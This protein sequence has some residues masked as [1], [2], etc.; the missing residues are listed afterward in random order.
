[1]AFFTK[2]GRKED[3]ND[4]INNKRTR[5]TTPSVHIDR[6]EVNLGHVG[7]HSNWRRECELTGNL[8]VTAALLEHCASVELSSV[9]GT[10]TELV[11]ASTQ[12]FQELGILAQTAVMA[13]ASTSTYIPAHPP[14]KPELAGGYDS[15]PVR[16]V[17]TSTEREDV[18][19]FH[20]RSQRDLNTTLPP[21]IPSIPE[22]YVYTVQSA[23]LYSPSDIWKLR[24]LKP[25]QRQHEYTRLR[26]I[27]ESI[28]LFS[29]DEQMSREIIASIKSK[30]TQ[31]HLAECN[32]Y[33]IHMRHMFMDGEYDKTK[34][35]IPWSVITKHQSF[36]TRITEDGQIQRVRDTSDYPPNV[37]NRASTC[38]HNLVETDD[39][40]N[41]NNS[42]RSSHSSHSKVSS[43]TSLS[44]TPSSQAGESARKRDA[45]ILLQQPTPTKKRRIN[46]V[47][48]Q[49]K[50]QILA[51]I[52][53]EEHVEAN[54]SRGDPL[55]IVSDDVIYEQNRAAIEEG[56]AKNPLTRKKAPE[57]EKL[58]YWKS[59]HSLIK[60]A[61]EKTQPSERDA[62]R[63]QGKA[64]FKAV[65]KD[66]A[67][68]KKAEAKKYA[69][70]TM[71]VAVAQ[72]RTGTAE[73][74][75]PFSMPRSHSAGTT[76]APHHYQSP[77]P[78]R[79]TIRP[80]S[81]GCKVTG[82]NH[83]EQAIDSKEL[84]EANKE[85][86]EQWY[87]ENFSRKQGIPIGG[88]LLKSNHTWYQKV[89]AWMKMRGLVQSPKTKRKLN[90]GTPVSPEPQEEKQEDCAPRPHQIR[91]SGDL[92]I[93]PE[94]PYDK[95]E[96]YTRAPDGRYA[97]SHVHLNPPKDCCKSGLTRAGK[98]SA[99]KKDI[100][101]WN[102]RIEKLIDNKE[103]DKRH[104]TWP[105]WTVPALRKKHQ[106][107]LWARQEAKTKADQEN[108]K[109]ADERQKKRL[110][111][112]SREDGQRT[113]VPQAVN[114]Q[115]AAARPTPM[116]GFPQRYVPQMIPTRAS[117][118]LLPVLQPPPAQP[119]AQ[120]PTAPMRRRSDPD[121]ITNTQTAL[122][123]NLARTNP[124]LLRSHDALYHDAQFRESLKRHPD[125]EMLRKWYL[126]YFLEQ[127][128]QPL[129]AEQSKLLESGDPS[130]DGKKCVTAVP[131]LGRVDELFGEYL[132]AAKAER[133][134]QR[135][136]EQSVQLVV[137]MG[138]MGEQSQHV[139]VQAPS[140]V[141]ETMA[142]TFDPSART[143]PYDFDELF[144]DTE[145]APL[146]APVEQP[147]S[148]KPFRI[149]NP[150][151]L[152]S[153]LKQILG[154]DPSHLAEPAFSVEPTAYDT[155]VLR[156]ETLYLT[157]LP[158]AFATGNHNV[159][160]EMQ[161]MLE[162]AYQT[163]A[164]LIVTASEDE[165]LLRRTI[166]ASR[167]DRQRYCDYFG[168][169][170]PLLAGEG[171]VEQQPIN[172]FDFGEPFT[173]AQQAMLDEFDDEPS[174]FVEYDA[175]IA[176]AQAANLAQYREAN[177][178]LE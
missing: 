21:N 42:P 162:Y 25:L 121:A 140:Q 124:R 157:T 142:V 113:P 146:D 16:T 94:Y 111:R 118:A 130:H 17:D 65:R 86:I 80:L 72:Q 102:G 52:T 116:P 4:C 106:A 112:M 15:I 147:M 156:T 152:D 173:E 13:G 176:A 149:L 44:P 91:Y 48:A 132:R 59:K 92:V 143:E 63:E 41:E 137:S 89:N 105:N 103:L 78:P 115:S 104:M 84:Y 31:L 76:V 30:S 46:V 172:E 19:D 34:R 74:S 2:R 161:T 126:A 128:R 58:A 75:T 159:N 135:L 5:T 83:T 154:L 38:A 167:S 79:P 68:D 36:T 119:S 57:W 95:I 23:P 153:E 166:E 138:H 27:C 29:S 8:A 88:K 12:E 67:N 170:Q 96:D 49:K 14:P 171:P 158:P 69:A 6:T 165:Q 110:Q 100:M 33:R 150:G 47:A 62:R 54:H 85:E 40:G 45:E 93:V 117:P 71:P 145:V 18:Q 114:Q 148:Q 144:A 32:F 37:T 87:D 98:K 125:F 134:A 7:I 51:T 82:D 139:G 160:N 24:H 11:M 123:A 108:R 122:F 66:A 174:L 9:E 22:T 26:E 77:A 28:E 55:S 56:W 64:N 133:E 136:Q 35:Y 107:A 151:E 164:K 53:V 131:A 163:E 73:L 141:A 43:A 129:T 127:E 97:C 50:A 61:A 60:E 20:N 70:S 169:E 120:R 90:D 101:R 39:S 178:S 99:I 177:N 109:K 3:D 10:G 1:M 168:N 175:R 81:S 155:T